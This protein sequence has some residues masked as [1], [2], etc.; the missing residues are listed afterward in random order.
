MCLTC[1]PRQL[2]FQCGTEMPKGWTPLL[3]ECRGW[4]SIVFP[5]HC[6]LNH[7]YGVISV[8]LSP[9]DCNL[10]IKGLHIRERKRTFIVP[11]LICLPT[12]LGAVFHFI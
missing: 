10:S 7:M 11:S 5:L 12:V 3:E 4:D 6:L 2:F 9:P 8:Y 1:D